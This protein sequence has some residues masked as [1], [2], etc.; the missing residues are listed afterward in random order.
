MK[1]KYELK[2]GVAVVDTEKFK[3]AKE[4]YTKTVDYVGVVSDKK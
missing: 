3:V 1:K 4:T 2:T